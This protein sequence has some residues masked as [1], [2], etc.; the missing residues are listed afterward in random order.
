MHPR[1]LF[2]EKSSQNSANRA[3]FVPYKRARVSFVSR[4]NNSE[5]VYKKPLVNVNS[6]NIHSDSKIDAGFAHPVQLPSN[7]LVLEQAK[8]ASLNFL[9]PKK[10]FTTGSYPRLQMTNSRQ[11]TQG[12]TE[13]SHMHG[14]TFGLEDSPN[15]MVTPIQLHDDESIQSVKSALAAKPASSGLIKISL[16]RPPL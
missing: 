6:Q 7:S 8:P 1:Q 12:D 10:E 5:I 13:E 11:S 4:N 15:D 9:T 14:Q 3:G 2:E 16:A